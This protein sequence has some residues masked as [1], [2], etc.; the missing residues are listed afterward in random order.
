ML[1]PQSF[2][3]SDPGSGTHGEAVKKVS[4]RGGARPGAGR[5]PKHRPPG[6]QKPGHRTSVHASQGSISSLNDTDK[7]PTK[8]GGQTAGSTPKRTERSTVSTPK[9]D[10]GQRKA[11]GSG[12]G[13]RRKTAEAEAE[14]ADMG[15]L[16][17]HDTFR[18][19]DDSASAAGSRGSRGGSRA[20][21]GA[22]DDDSDVVDRS[23]RK[24]QKPLR[25]RDDEE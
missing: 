1:N 12:A 11:P 4:K 6:V 14:D 13:K 7:S 18:P 21:G 25:Y 16:Y 15:G 24:R 17:R 5:K 23:A 3:G 19:F 2:S 20:R 10:S 8:K 9:R 22:D